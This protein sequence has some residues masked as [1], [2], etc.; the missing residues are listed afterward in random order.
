MNVLTGTFLAMT[1]IALILNIVH[2]RKKGKIC[3]DDETDDFC[4]YFL[5]IS[6]LVAILSLTGWIKVLL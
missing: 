5:F 4:F 2:F 6:L 1:A 3:L